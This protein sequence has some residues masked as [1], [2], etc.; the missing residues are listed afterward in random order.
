MERSVNTGPVAVL[1]ES[2]ARRIAAGEVIERPASVVRELLDNSID[3]GAASVTVEI[4][5]GGL[6]SIR[7]DDDGAGMSRDDLELCWKP[8]ATSKISRAEDLTHCRTLGFRGEA[9]SSVAAVSRLEIRSRQAGAE[10]GHRLLVSNNRLEALEPAATSP[11]TT[12]AVDGL[13]YNLPGRKR[14]LKTPRSE[15]QQIRKVI[16]EKALPQPEIRFRLIAD[17]KEQLLLPAGSLEERAGALFGDK[18]APQSIHR[19]EGSGEGF[20]LTVLAADPSQVRRDRKQIYTFVNGRRLR[21]YA[22]LQAV[23]YAFTDTM[24]GGLYP[25]A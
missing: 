2:V 13:F 12:V 8:H 9:L 24:H 25:Y 11:G 21:E 7:V 22:L 1:P 4:R 10:A 6:E 5:S 16:L 18:V 19:L 17:G 15:A 23:D 14:F 20:S 3:A